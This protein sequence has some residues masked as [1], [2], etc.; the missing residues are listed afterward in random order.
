M[1]KTMTGN[2]H[3]ENRHHDHRHN[4]ID[5]FHNRH[6]PTT[7][8]V[9]SR[10]HDL[11][12]QKQFT[13]N[14]HLSVI[15]RTSHPPLIH[16]STKTSIASPINTRPPKDHS[17]QFIQREHQSIQSTK[18]REYLSEIDHQTNTM[19]PKQTRASTKAKEL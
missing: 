2:Y 11:E 13:I 5:H 16:S 4:V 18:R 10:I 3:F 9:P 7:L 1:Q 15:A 19:A 6:R 17:P 14:V 12:R 8:I